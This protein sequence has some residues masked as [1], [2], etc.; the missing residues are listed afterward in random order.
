MAERVFA[1]LGVDYGIIGEGERFG[2]L[3]EALHQGLDP[4]QIPG[5]ISPGSS[6]ATPEPW[7]GKQVRAFRPHASHVGFYLKRGGMLNLQ[8]KRGCSFR[9]IYCPYPH[10]EGKR[11][12][13]VPPGEVARTALDLQEAGAKYLFLTDSAF[14]SDIAHSLAVAKAFKDAGV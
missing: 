10:L 12:R 7:T 4:R 6:P 1:A 9:C 3:V 13:L 5:V 8:S 14:N 11:H 2:L